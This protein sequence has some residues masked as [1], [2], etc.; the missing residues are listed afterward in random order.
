MSRAADQR[1]LRACICAGLRARDGRASWRRIAAQA[2]AMVKA[3][4]HGVICTQA[5]RAGEAV[6]VHLRRLIVAAGFQP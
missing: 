4:G 2:D 1:A 6:G 3:G 5:A